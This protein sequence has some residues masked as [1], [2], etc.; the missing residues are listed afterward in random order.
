MPALAQVET[1]ESITLFHCTNRIVENGLRVC[2]NAFVNI[3]VGLL[4]YPGE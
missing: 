3:W 2:R 4:P 1:V